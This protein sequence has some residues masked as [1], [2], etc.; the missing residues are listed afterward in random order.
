VELAVG[1]PEEA[2]LPG[3]PG[4][5]KYRHQ[6]EWA[7]ATRRLLRIP[8]TGTRWGVGVSADRREED[9]PKPSS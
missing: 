5:R 8:Q 1:D 2:C 6:G 9:N 7:A 4:L 3:I